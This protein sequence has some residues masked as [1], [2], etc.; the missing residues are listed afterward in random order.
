MGDA[1]EWVR[2]WGQVPPAAPT[3]DIMSCSHLPSAVLCPWLCLDNAKILAPPMAT[4]TTSVE[5]WRH[6]RRATQ[7]N[8]GLDCWPLETETSYLA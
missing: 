1:S 6:H 7:M 2:E 8:I 3:N 5:H 4:G